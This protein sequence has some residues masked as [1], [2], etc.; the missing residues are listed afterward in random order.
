MYEISKLQCYIALEIGIRLGSFGP[1]LLRMSSTR[2]DAMVLYDKEAVRVCT[3]KRGHRR[4]A[5]T[6]K[7]YTGCWQGRHQ[8]ARRASCT[9]STSPETNMHVRKNKHRHAHTHT[10][11]LHLSH[12]VLQCPTG[13]PPFDKIHT[14]VIGSSGNTG[15][16]NARQENL[17]SIR[18]TQ[19]L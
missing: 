14:G 6:Y 13:K 15:C 19:V 3:R 10:H 12:F 1:D 4:S 7:C 2:Y 9:T 8:E 16:F 18:S 11:T 5:T 17:P